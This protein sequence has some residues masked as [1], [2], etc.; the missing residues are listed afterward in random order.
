MAFSP[1]VA[2]APSTTESVEEV[3]VA[4]FA[5][6]NAKNLQGLMALYAEDA[7]LLPSSGERIA[8]S[9]KIRDYFRSVLDSPCLSVRESESQNVVSSGDLAYDSGTWLQAGAHGSW[10]E[11]GA[12]TVRG[13]FLVVLRRE[14]DKWL[15]V[16]HASTACPIVYAT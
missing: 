5:N 2:F 1:S 7:V 15:I 9:A 3:R 13:S 4:W 8:G 10:S 16:Q 12:G 14:A 11:A 6:W